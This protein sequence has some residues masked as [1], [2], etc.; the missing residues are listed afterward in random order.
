MRHFKKDFEEEERKALIEIEKGEGPP[1]AKK[2]QGMA[3]SYFRMPDG[4]IV[5]D[6][7]SLPEINESY[8]DYFR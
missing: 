2:E 4:S 3:R 6:Q 1:P 5:F 7:S 8:R